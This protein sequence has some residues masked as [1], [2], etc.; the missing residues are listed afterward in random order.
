MRWDLAELLRA[1]EATS[2]DLTRCSA[3][4]VSPHPHRRL[5]PSLSSENFLNLC[6]HLSR[7]LGIR[8]PGLRGHRPLSEGAEWVF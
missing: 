8:I 1:C 3:G 4:P 7:K 2:L 6:C 5:L